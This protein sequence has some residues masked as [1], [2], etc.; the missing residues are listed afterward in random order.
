MAA[1]GA[2]CGGD[3]LGSTE[4]AALVTGQSSSRPVASLRVPGSHLFVWAPWCT[5][6]A[7]LPHCCFNSFNFVCCIFSIGTEIQR[8]QRRRLPQTVPTALTGFRDL[9]L[10][11]QNCC[12]VA[13]GRRCPGELKQVGTSGISENPR[14]SYHNPAP[15]RV[16]GDHGR[17]GTHTQQHAA[18]ATWLPRCSQCAAPEKTRFPTSASSEKLFQ[19]QSPHKEC[20]AGRAWVGACIAGVGGA[21]TG[22]CG[23]LPGWKVGPAP[24]GLE[25]PHGAR[26][27]WLGTREGM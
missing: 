9:P 20:A 21:N 17:P 4:N 15:Q 5:L 16:G 27:A 7:L 25:T 10:P 1:P 14:G 18:P 22:S 3:G 12:K 8:I 23:H 11:C 2:L 13:N 19:G 26:E 24:A 6:R